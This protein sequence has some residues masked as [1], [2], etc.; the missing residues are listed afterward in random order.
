LQTNLRGQE[1]SPN[2]SLVEFDFLVVQMPQSAAI[3]LIP[4][5]RDNKR[6]ENAVA[7]ILDLVA[8][9]KAT[10]IGWP[11]VAIFSGQRAVAEQLEEFRYATE[12]KGAERVRTIERY[13]KDSGT[14]GAPVV[15]VNPVDAPPKAPEPEKT[16]S[17][18]REFDAVPTSFETRNIGVS[19]EIEPVVGPD[20]R[21][22]EL[23][24]VPRHVSLFEMRRVEIEDK[25]SGRKTVV[26]QPEFHTNV[27][28]TS[29][30]VQDG[31]YTLL[32][33][34]KVQK[35]QGYM[36]LFILHTQI[37]K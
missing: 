25:G 27:V 33:T 26:E 13:P 10:L 15:P 19:L 5:L 24:L 30:R 6:S 11:V 16:T 21:T 32:G 34:F 8:S 7:R 35:P 31:D 9:N 36:E 12:Y 23:S 2:R 17:V 18:H 20:G 14:P 22:I 1:D 29:I 4:Q 37:K 28:T 3:S